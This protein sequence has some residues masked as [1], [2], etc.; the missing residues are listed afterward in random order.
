MAGISGG[1]KMKVDYMTMDKKMEPVTKLL[2]AKQPQLALDRLLFMMNRNLFTLEE[3]WR[4]YQRLGDCYFDLMDME[5]AQ[6]AYWAALNQTQGLP[7]QKQRY[8]YSN[9]LFLLH[10]L[11]DKTKEF[12]HERNFGYQK[13]FVEDGYPPI[14]YNHNKIRVGYIAPNFVKNVVSFFSVQLLSGYD[15][16]RFEVYIY[17]ILPDEDVLTEELRKHVTVWRTFPQG[18]LSTQIAEIIHQD[19]IDILF[20]LTVHTDGGLTLPIMSTHPASVQV[21]G[22]GYMSTSGLKSIDYFLTDVYLDPPEQHDEDFSE[23][24]LRLPHSHLCYTPPERALYCKKAWQLHQPI[25]FGSFNNFAKITDA[26]LVVWKKI[27]DQ[28]SGSKLLLKNG[29]M[30]SWNQRQ[31]MDRLRNLGFKMEQVKIEGSTADYLDRYM[32]IDIIL[33][34]YP[35][36]GGSTT[37]DALFRGVPVISKYGESHGTR[38]GYSLLANLGMEELAV[39]SDDEYIAKAVSLANDKERLKQLHSKIHREMRKSPLMDAAGYVREVERVYKNI[40]CIS[41]GSQESKENVIQD[42]EALRMML[43]YLDIM[44]VNGMAALKNKRY[45]LAIHYFEDWW[46]IRKEYYQYTWQRVRFYIGLAFYGMGQYHEAVPCFQSYRKEN[47]YDDIAEFYYGNL[48]YHLG[49]YEEAVIVYQNLINRH[50]GFKE[51]K[52]NFMIASGKLEEGNKLKSEIL[53]PEICYENEFQENPCDDIIKGKAYDSFSTP[54]FINVRDRVDC[55]KKLINWLLD[56]GY[57]NIHL[58]D[59]ASTYQPLLEYFKRIDNDSRVK[60]HFLKKNLG[61]KALWDSNILEKLQI[62]RPYVYSDPDVIP[63]QNCPK[64]VVKR[65]FDL[66][67]ANPYCIKA[68]LGLHYEDITY[69]QSSK[70]KKYESQY[71]TVPVGDNAY[72]ANLD[73]TFALYRNIR[74]YTYFSCIRTTG[75]MM[76][77][78]IPWYYEKEKDVPLDEQYYMKHAN[79]SSSFW[80][81]MKENINV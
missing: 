63:D 28:V 20:D 27:L 10:Y 62:D 69:A 58:L 37:C 39:T 64:D 4:V 54:I 11:P 35:Y 71:Y 7:I 60:I 38:F 31:I 2:L 77:R 68:G 72:F 25:V 70:M 32:D 23:K 78:H 15:R 45:K 53:D 16:E 61:H 41:N 76:V 79:T 43:P 50:A 12:L 49:E 80:Q 9:Y 1:H 26:M 47:K 13:L 67:E 42:D 56:A 59:N 75:D 19:E 52:I 6:Q 46:L 3:M 48:L 44:L 5:K 8:I 30:R 81:A 66:L 36:T 33:D 34:T 14:K 73:T 65:L 57:T 17:S 40:L 21:A 22:I 74:F 55:L 18:T 51:A 24:L 29:S